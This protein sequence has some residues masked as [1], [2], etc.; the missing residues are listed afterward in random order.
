MVYTG[1]GEVLSY[2]E[3]NGHGHL[4]RFHNRTVAHREDGV[5]ELERKTARIGE[6]HPKGKTG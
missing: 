6:G 1:G 2:D 3:S 4:E 5:A